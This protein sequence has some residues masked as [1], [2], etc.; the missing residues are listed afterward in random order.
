MKQ[1]I[2]DM[3]NKT[4][5][6]M[7]AAFSLTLSVASAQDVG[8]TERAS[9]S[10]K[11]VTD[12]QHVSVDVNMVS[13]VPTIDEYSMEFTYVTAHPGYDVVAVVT[14]NEYV[15]PDKVEYYT[16]QKYRSN[17]REVFK[18]TKPIFSARD[19]LSC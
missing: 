17:K 6:L 5:F 11:I 19:K 8:I 18:N 3:R 2:C 4:I 7:L 13:L 14:K 12:A 1:Y 9:V 16:L 10:K 15:S